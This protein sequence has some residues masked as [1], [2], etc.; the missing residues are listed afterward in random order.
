M[1][2]FLYTSAWGAF[3][4]MLLF[5]IPFLIV[6][7]RIVNKKAFVDSEPGKTAAGKYSYARYGWLA[8]VVGA[9]IVV[10][11]AS[12]KYMPTII[13]AKAAISGDVR[14]VNVTARSWAFEI[15]DKDKEYKVGETVRFLAKS[16]D[17]VHSFA[18]IHPDGSQIFTMM[19][20]PGAGVDSA[21][22]H[23][24][25]EPGEYT[26]RCLEFCGAAHH[27]MKSTLTVL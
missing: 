4:T 10:N 3:I 6:F 9:F 7:Y 27:A 15:S 19:L 21:M 12:I 24:F 2:D 8:L 5:Q 13:E 20:V 11:I 17:T 18:L 22:V 25:T 23:T 16:E 26:V 14:N 1:I